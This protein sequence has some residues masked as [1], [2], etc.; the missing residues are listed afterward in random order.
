MS[1]L[2]QQLAESRIAPLVIRSISL[3]KVLTTALGDNETRS[4]S[5]TSHLARFKLWSGSL[6]AHHQSGGRSLEYRLRDASF[7]RNHVVSLLTDLCKSLDGGNTN[8]R[9]EG[10]CVSIGQEEDQDSDDDELAD[11]FQSDDASTELDMDLTLHEIGHVV[12]C[13]L[14]LS[15]TIR[16]PAPHDQFKSRAGAGVIEYYEPYDIQHIREKYPHVDDGLI[17]KL[18][19]DPDEWT[20]YADRRELATTVA[21]SLPEHLKDR[22]EKQYSA[23]NELAGLDDQMSEAS[24]TSYAPSNADA[25]Q[26]HVPP[27]P[28]AHLEGPFKCPFCYVVI[29]IDT[30]YAWKKHVFRDLQPYICLSAACSMPHHLYSCRSEWAKHMRKD[31][32]KTWK[33]FFGCSEIFSTAEGFRSHVET[34][35]KENFL[36]SRLDT[37]ENLSS[38]QEFKK[39]EQKCPLCFEV[40]IKSARQYETHVG[41]HLE[42]LALFTLPTLEIDGEEE[43]QDDDD[44]DDDDRDDDEDQELQKSAKE[45]WSI[46]SNVLQHYEEAVAE[47]MEAVRLHDKH[48]MGETE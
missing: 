10:E 31:H 2:G 5:V 20:D 34:N 3:F 26:L 17:E 4:S 25:N 35:H 11:Y 24:K 13:L 6:G 36:V 30:K 43:E 29:S 32:W 22:H 48:A 15:I 12:D 42:N 14:R 16:N 33:C 44:D 18:G 37:F 1:E 41:S 45:P 9:D 46:N 38:R 7:I 40:E 19:M 47:E 27:I 28:K 39:L 21:S 8:V 23:G